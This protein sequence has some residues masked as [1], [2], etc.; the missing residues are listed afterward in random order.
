MKPII[1]AS[2][3]L[4]NLFAHMNIYDIGLENTYEDNWLYVAFYPLQV[5]DEEFTYHGI[6]RVHI[7]KWKEKY[8]C[9]KLIPMKF[10]IQ[11]ET[12]IVYISGSNLDAEINQLGESIVESE[13]FIA[14]VTPL[15][16]QGLREYK[17]HY[18]LQ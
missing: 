5:Y 7:F 4:T 15:L 8:Q 6:F 9:L 11:S 13:K 17:I 16:I 2:F 3:L 1:E 14:E 12:T 18:L 10:R